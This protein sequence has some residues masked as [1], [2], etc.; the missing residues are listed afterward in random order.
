MASLSRIARCGSKIFS[1]G[2][3]ATA[4]GRGSFTITNPFH[5]GG[6]F[7]V[8]P[9]SSLYSAQVVDTRQQVPGRLSVVWE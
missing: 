6:S 4:A 5:N 2:T 3:R 1:A 9:S 8:I 7:F